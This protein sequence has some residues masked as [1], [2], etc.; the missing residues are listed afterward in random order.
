MERTA[1]ADTPR[2]VPGVT[3]TR[4]R[5]ARTLTGARWSEYRGLLEYALVMGYRVIS[6]ER[7]L[8]EGDDPGL[9][10]LILRHDVDQC[11]GS[12]RRMLAAER[13]LGV[14]ATWY[15][16]WRTADPRAIDWIRNAGGEVGLHYE[17]L[18]RRLLN[19][20]GPR[21]PE[22][23][24]ASCREELAGEI[25]S[26]Q[27]HFGPIRSVCPHG[28]S[29][30]PGSSNQVLLR[31]V[32][33]T[34][35]GVDYD[36]NDALSKR[37]LGVWLTDRSTPDGRWKDGMDPL[38]LLNGHC[39]PML[40]LTHPNN[41]I[42]G[43]ALWADRIAAA[44]L[45]APRPAARR[46]LMRTGSDEVPAV[47]KG[48]VP[49]PSA[50]APVARTLEREVR[51]YYA[52]R[53]DA[54]TGQAGL[55]TLLTNSAFAERRA[56]TLL[57]VLFLHSDVRSL[58]GLRVLDVGCGFG[59]LA[60]VFASRGAVVTALDPNSERSA[61]GRRVAEHHDLPVTFRRGWIEEIVLGTEDF[62]LVVLNNSFCYLLDLSA[63]RVALSHI[64]ASL[65]PGGW[66]A[67]RNPN[68][69]FPIDQFTG[70]PLLGVLSPRLAK[71]SARLVGR[72]RSEVRL[73]T[74]WAQRRELGGAGYVDVSAGT[75]HR[76]VWRRR[77]VAFARYQHVV[78]RRPSEAS[79][80]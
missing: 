76:D 14:T 52:G 22:A 67:M 26:F 17:T 41:L 32:D 16:R 73:Q 31:S 37:R 40:C 63:R 11:P 4:R 68:R 78:A 57:E 27:E 65:K 59:A 7:W 29:R 45:P 49:E 8:D 50:F 48:R 23:L 54:P 13:A 43:P 12:V 1:Q 15:F 46:L 35:F 34:R 3:P 6:L 25:A 28:D 74:V 5:L 42:S 70:L 10:T 75:P 2:Q 61:V 64:R 21:E 77:L 72:H 44:A 80:A 79:R 30:V 33:V 36:G 60:A 18:T 55:N 39:T 20:R 56:E 58:A 53:T 69:L 66:L 19:Q 38:Q 51:A 62:D 9:P 47:P 24:I 71:G